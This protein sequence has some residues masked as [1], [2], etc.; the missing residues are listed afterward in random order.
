[1]KPRLLLIP[2]V[3]PM[4]FL[5]GCILTTRPAWD[6]AIEKK[7]NE[8]KASALVVA[9]DRRVF[10]VSPCG[11]KIIAEPSPDAIRNFA[12]TFQAAITAAEK[13]KDIAAS[14]NL[15]SQS[16][17]N[18]LPLNVRSQGVIFLRDSSYRLAEAYFNGMLDKGEYGA[19]FKEVIEAS[20]RLINLE[21][22]QGLPVIKVSDGKAP[23]PT[24]ISTETPPR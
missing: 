12:S 20:E 23:N 4:F 10:L 14:L 22:K 15:V 24:N 17:N 21:I 2:A 8:S 11:D 3:L 9:A 6:P 16:I 13:S 7:L 18:A 1:M 5:S 19:H